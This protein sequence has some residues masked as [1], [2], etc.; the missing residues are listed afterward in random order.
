[1]QQDS[2]DFVPS[3]GLDDSDSD[4]KSELQQKYDAALSMAERLQLKVDE[5]QLQ[6]N[7]LERLKAPP[8]QPVLGRNRLQKWK[9]K[10]ASTYHDK[11]DCTGFNFRGSELQ[12]LSPCGICVV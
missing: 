5:L 6:I 4:A 10:L 11:S 12:E 8:P 9:T 7:E 1:M 2:S 3:Q